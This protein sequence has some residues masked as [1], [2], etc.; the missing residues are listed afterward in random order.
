MRLEFIGAFTVFDSKKKVQ[1]K[2]VYALCNAY[3]VFGS[4]IKNCVCICNAYTVF[5]SPI[6]NCVCNK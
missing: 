5:D 2:T 4:P 6:K 3:T 1:S